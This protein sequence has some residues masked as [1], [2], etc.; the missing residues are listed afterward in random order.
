MRLWDAG[1]AYT[2]IKRKSTF[3][4]VGLQASFLYLAL[5]ILVGILT[6]LRKDIREFLAEEIHQTRE[7]A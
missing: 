5:R 4:K 6:A 2:E 3:W 1:L 7:N